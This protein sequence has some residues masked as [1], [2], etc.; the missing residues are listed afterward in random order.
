MR[1]VLQDPNHQPEM[2]PI[3]AG[4]HLLGYFW[5]V[6]PTPAGHVLTHAELRA[7]QENNGLELAP[8]ETR[9]L[10]RLSSDYLAETFKARRQDHPAPWKPGGEAFSSINWKVTQ[11]SIRKLANL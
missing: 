6:G 3:E 2:P 1:E 4:G 8:W 11:R 10:R 7:W 5:D 9:T